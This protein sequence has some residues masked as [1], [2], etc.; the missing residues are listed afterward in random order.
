MQNS[1]YQTDLT[2]A[3]VWTQR[4]TQSLTFLCTS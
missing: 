1:L 2:C 4:D 3:E